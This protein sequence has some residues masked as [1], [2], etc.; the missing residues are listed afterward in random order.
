MLVLFVICFFVSVYWCVS[1]L[2]SRVTRLV[3]QR[4]ASRQRVVFLTFD[5]GPGSRLTPKVLQVLKKHNVKAT[6]F[7]LGEMS[8]VEKIL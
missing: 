3:L 8:S 2:C 5:D 6:F 1:W 7:C 4:K